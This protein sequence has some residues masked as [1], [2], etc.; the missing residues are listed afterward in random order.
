MK[1]GQYISPKFDPIQQKGMS[2]L[3]MEAKY[4]S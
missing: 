2:T 4:S 3:K 1:M